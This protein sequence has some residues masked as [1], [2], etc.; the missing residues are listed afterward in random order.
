MNKDI[1]KNIFKVCL[2]GILIYLICAGFMLW[3]LG[4]SDWRPVTNS[5]FDGIAKSF[6]FLKK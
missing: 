3:A 1:A 5:I 6:S 4:S 2:A